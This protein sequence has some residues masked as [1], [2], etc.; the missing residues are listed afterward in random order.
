MVLAR[1]ARG[2]VALGASEKKSFRV[3]TLAW[4]DTPQRELFPAR[5][6]EFARER[7]RLARQRRAM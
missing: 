5:K 6:T 4:S 2:A 1:N 3:E 7:R